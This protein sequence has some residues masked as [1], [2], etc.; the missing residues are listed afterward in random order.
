MGWRLPTL[1]ELAS[2]VDSSVPVPGPS[3]PAGHPFSNVQ[4]S[5]PY[6]SATTCALRSTGEWFLFFYDGA[7]GVGIGGDFFA[8]CVRGGQG[9]NP[10]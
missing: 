8:W 1:Q 2:L 6:W 9:V 5:F 3:L 4:Q 7:S 10:Q